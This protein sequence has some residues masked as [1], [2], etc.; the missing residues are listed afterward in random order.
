MGGV[1]CCTEPDRPAKRRLKSQDSL[2]LTKE[3]RLSD[4]LKQLPR[5]KRTHEVTDTDE[6]INDAPLIL[7]T[8]RIRGNVQSLRYQMKYSKINFV[9]EHYEMDSTGKSPGWSSSQGDLELDFPCLPYLFDS[10]SGIRMSD[11]NAIATYLATTYNRELLG[12]TLQEKA[13][14]DMCQNEL[15]I[16]RKEFTFLMYT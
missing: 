5:S 11:Q 15:K 3:K 4:S 10:K 7:G 6:P 14:V 1:V 8:W 9:E 13:K 12:V 2:I 16:K